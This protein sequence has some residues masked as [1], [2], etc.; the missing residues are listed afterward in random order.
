MDREQ[1]FNIQKI[2]NLYAYGL[3]SVRFLSSILTCVN[4]G[5]YN[6]TSDNYTK[7]NNINM[8]IYAAENQ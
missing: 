7:V 8:T 3:T 4:W 1:I 5:A 2:F 6:K